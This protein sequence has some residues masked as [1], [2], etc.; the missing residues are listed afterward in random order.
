MIKFFEFNAE[1]DE[2]VIINKKRETIH[3]SVSG[4]IS[5]FFFSSSEEMKK[6]LGKY[7]DFS[8][9]IREINISELKKNLTENEIS[10]LLGGLNYSLLEK[11]RT[12]LL[13]WVTETH[14]DGYQNFHPSDRQPV[15]KKYL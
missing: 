14:S 13:E 10:S 8:L 7:Y 6:F 5:N 12:S 3:T 1:Y 11:G 2:E 9:S 4:Y 15:I